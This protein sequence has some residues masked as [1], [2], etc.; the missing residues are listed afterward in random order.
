[1][2][3][4]SGMMFC[5]DCGAKLCQIRGKV[6]TH[7]KEYFVCATDRKKK[8]M[9]SSYQIR[10]VVVEQLL[11]EDLRRVMSFA[12]DHEQGFIR[13]VMNHLEKELA[14]E[15]SLNQKGYEQAQGRIITL[16]K[17][18]QKLYEDMCWVKSRRNV[19]TRWRLNM[20]PNRK[21]LRQRW[22]C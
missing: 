1:M 16:D 4:L 11:L 10:N 2:C 21:L 18:I 22:L 5:A 13:V 17:I 20:K 12:K 19:F 6:W 9:C 15:L 8:G 7:D 14:K 3:I